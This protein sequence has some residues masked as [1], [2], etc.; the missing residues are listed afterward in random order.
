MTVCPPGKSTEVKLLESVQSKATALVY[1]L[2]K[3]NS[4]ERRKKLGLS[5]WIQESKSGVEGHL[6][7]KLEVLTPNLPPVLNFL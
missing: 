3:V 4:E 1:G 2:K 5:V 6:T 7:S